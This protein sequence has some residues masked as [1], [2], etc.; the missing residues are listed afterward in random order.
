MKSIADLSTIILSLV[1]KEITNDITPYRAIV[2]GQSGGMVQFRPIEAATAATQLYARI[3]GFSLTIGDE[4]MVIGRKNPIVLGRIQRTAPASFAL[5]ASFDGQTSQVVTFGPFYRNDLAASATATM[6]AGF[7]DAAATVAQSTGAIY[8]PRNGEIVGIYATS[9]ANRTSG[10]ATI[11][12]VVDGVAQTFDGGATCVLDA[13]N[14][15][16]HSVHVANGDGEDVTAG[17]RV[18]LQAV[19][20]GWGPTTANLTAWMAIR[21]DF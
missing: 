6:Q 4:I 17:Q 3:A 5:D 21:L 1:R 11:Q 8:I 10:T 19:T 15:R 16:R 7:F 14:T 18:E 12:P 13:T 2:T 20:S 9:D